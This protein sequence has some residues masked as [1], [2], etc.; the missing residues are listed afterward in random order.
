M[1]LHAS[2]GFSTSNPA[3]ASQAGQPRQRELIEDSQAVG[4]PLLGYTVV[5]AL[6]GIEVSAADA[7]AI[8]KPHTY[9]VQDGTTTKVKTLDELLPGLPEPATV[10]KRAIKA[11]MRELAPVDLGV[12]ADE[13]I[14]LR[15]VTRSS[16]DILVVALV[17]ELAD[18]AEWGLSYLT[19]LRVFYDKKTS[20]LSLNRQAS[21][22]STA[23]VDQRDIDLLAQL[24]PKF[25]YYQDIYTI[26]E[27]GRWCSN[28]LDT[29]DTI[30]MKEKG[31]TYSVPYARL[32]RL[33]ELKDILEL[34]MPSGP[35]MTNSSALHAI[36]VIDRPATRGQLSQIAHKS[37]MGDLDTLETDLKRFIDQVKKITFTK[38]GRAKSHKVKQETVDARLNE[39][40]RM[41]DRI[42]L[43]H[44]TLGLRQEELIAR[45]ESFEKTASELM[46]TATD[47][48]ASQMNLDA[49]VAALL[50]DA[51]EASRRQ[52]T[53]SSESGE[54][55]EPATGDQ[56][57]E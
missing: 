40:R 25:V 36:P 54:S 11:W 55:L 50:G 6:K 45:L 2:A 56:A 32:A 5:T 24:E 7:E 26:T 44:A 21:G 30:R 43:Y 37:I 8:L 51:V 28:V 41:R 29:M 15:D 31:G 39:Y 16:A 20:V 49:D 57:S 22:Q 17:V 38:S 47:A 52:V 42:Q 3:P 12:N 46:E 13:K 35:N 18:L 53:P 9:T 33:Q 34:E 19:N 10:L 14:L 23:T 1:T 4:F 48:M 27:I